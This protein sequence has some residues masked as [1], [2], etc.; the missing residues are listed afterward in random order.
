VAKV[1]L[2]MFDRKER[3]LG[4]LHEDEVSGKIINV[5]M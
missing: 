3:E 5:M 2:D 1:Y 4:L